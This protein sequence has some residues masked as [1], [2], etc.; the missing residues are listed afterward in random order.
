MLLPPASGVM[1]CERHRLPLSDP[2]S[3][4]VLFLVL[5]RDAVMIAAIYIMEYAR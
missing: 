2:D 5:A 3:G 4:G 1:N